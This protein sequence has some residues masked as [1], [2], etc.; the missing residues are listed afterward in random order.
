MPI[1]MLLADGELIDPN[2]AQSIWILVLFLVV[3]IIL[4]KTAWKNVLV[5]LRARE[6]RIRQDIADAEA[7][8]V[9]AEQTL[10]QYDARLA[11]AEEK[12]REIIDRAAVDAEKIA[13]GMRMKA[14]QEAEVVKEQATKEIE[15]AK[16][17][18]LTEIYTQ[19]ADLATSIA[20]KIIRRKINPDDQRDLVNQGIEE[21]QNARRN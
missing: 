10:R 19:T 9:K 3:A 7:A 16:Q 8:R 13:T 2:L 15:A 12:V 1:T 17:T 21:F 5:G 18:A 4:Y 20:E 6:D 11:G 14:Q